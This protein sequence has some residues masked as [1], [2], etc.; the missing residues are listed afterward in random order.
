VDREARVTVLSN[1]RRANAA[2]MVLLVL[3]AVSGAGLAV[4]YWLNADIAI[5]ASCLGGSLLLLAAGLIVWSHHLVPEG[6]FYEDYPDFQSPPG[7]EAK[8]LATLE[9][10]GIGRRRALLGALSAVG[11]TMTAGLLSTLRSLGPAPNS[12]AS[13]VWK[14][15]LRLVDAD[16]KPVKVGDLEVGGEISVYPEGFIESPMVA[17][18]LIQLPSGAN[19]PLPGR[20]SWAPG[21]LICYSKVCSHAGCPV[22]LYDH[23]SMDMECPCHQSAFDVTRGAKVVF[24]PAAGPLAQLPLRID[25]DGT[26]R[27]AGDF[28]E[29][30]GPVFWHYNSHNA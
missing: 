28:S 14:D 21:N 25:P 23:R 11:L 27:S 4:D 5:E 26:L 9:R 7:A 6:P 10:G 18:M 3:S 20:G 30:P 22:N 19:H 8:V 2:V 24:G 29:P 13:T 17:C 15:K 16:G 12:L 1:E